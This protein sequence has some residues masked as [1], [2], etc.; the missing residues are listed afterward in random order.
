MPAISSAPASAGSARRRGSSGSSW[1]WSPRRMV[2]KQ[3]CTPYGDRR[4]HTL[5]GIAAN[6]HW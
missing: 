1:R 6:L 4:L 5:R 2:R 3:A